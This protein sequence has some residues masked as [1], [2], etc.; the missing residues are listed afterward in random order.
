M[1]I[2]DFKKIDNSLLYSDY[3]KYEYKFGD[4]DLMSGG[5]LLGNSV[6]NFGLFYYD[7]E[8]FIKA[9]DEARFLFKLKE[10]LTLYD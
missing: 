4:L 6:M 2:T 9:Q 10:D 7:I 8:D 1:S 5:G 3:A